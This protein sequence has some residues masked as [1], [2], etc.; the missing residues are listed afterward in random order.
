MN[1]NEDVSSPPDH[2]VLVEVDAKRVDAGDEHVEPE[3]E[4]VAVDEQRVGDVALNYDRVL[5]LHL[6][7]IVVMMVV[8]M[9]SMM[10]MVM[11]R[12]VVMGCSS[13]Q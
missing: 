12:V 1:S 2:P 3:V 9:V 5:L 6:V 13:A 10:M 8:M 11:V 4:L 7:M